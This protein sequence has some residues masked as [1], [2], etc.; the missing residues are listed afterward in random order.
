MESD[1]QGRRSAEHIGHVEGRRTGGR[2][3]EFDEDYEYEY[4]DE[5]GTVH[6]E[7]PVQK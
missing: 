5:G 6:G 3:G 2:R 7:L 4:E 1:A